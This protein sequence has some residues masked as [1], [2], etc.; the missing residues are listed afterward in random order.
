ISSVH[1]GPFQSAY[2]GYWI[3]QRLAGNGYMPEAV[4][5]TLRF[6][7]EQ[8]GLHRLQ[9]SI[10]PRNTASRRVVEKLGLRN[11]GVAERYLEINGVWEDHIRYAVTAEEWQIRKNELLS[12]W[13]Y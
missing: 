10:I 6:A 1:R 7:F 9:I 11:E 5:L 4:V 12:A 3:D 2:I 13:A 8:M